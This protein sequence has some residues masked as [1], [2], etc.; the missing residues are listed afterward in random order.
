MKIRQLLTEETAM[1]V[2]TKMATTI[3]P[4]ASKLNG[5]TN[6]SCFGRVAHYLKQ[7]RNPDWYILLFGFQE[8]GEVTHCCL[9]DND[10]N[11][12]VDTFDGAPKNIGGNIVYVDKHNN[13]HELLASMNVAQFEQRFLGQ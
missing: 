6:N 2:L 10:G 12:V 4:S 7:H 13:E 1:V 11:R 3:D 9:Y 8:N 5:Y